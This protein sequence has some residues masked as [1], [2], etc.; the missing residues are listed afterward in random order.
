MVKKATVI[1]SIMPN[2]TFNGMIQKTI[3]QTHSTPQHQALS[4]RYS[5]PILTLSMM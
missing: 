5:H 4:H 3:Y 2:Q 1:T